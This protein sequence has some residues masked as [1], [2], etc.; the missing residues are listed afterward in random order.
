[1]TNYNISANL[2]GAGAIPVGTVVSTSG[3]QVRYNF[4]GGT[5]SDS[6]GNGNN[7]T[8]TG[9]P[10]P[11]FGPG[12]TGQAAVFN[13]GNGAVNLPGFAVGL[14]SATG[15]FSIMAW[16]NGANQSNILFGGRNSTN[17]NAIIDLV[18]DFNGLNNGYTGYA[19]IIVTDNGG[20]GQ[21]AVNGTVALN[22]N[23]WHHVCAVFNGSPGVGSQTL[24]LYV[25]GALQAG[26]TVA[27]LQSGITLDNLGANIGFEYLNGWATT[28]S[29]DD[30]RFY[31][32]ALTA[33]EIAVIFSGVTGGGLALTQAMAGRAAWLGAG[34][35]TAPLRQSLAGK[36]NW[37]G[38]GATS[39]Q[40]QLNMRAGAAWGG[41][42][43]LPSVAAQKSGVLL[44][45]NF[46][47]GGS[48]ASAAR[49]RL[50]AGALLVGSISNLTVSPRAIFA[51]QARL[52]GTG[53]PAL[54]LGQIQTNVAAAFAGGGGVG[55]DFPPYAHMAQAALSGAG[56]LTGWLDWIGSDPINPG[57]LETAGEDLLY[58][59]AS[60]LEKSLATV[61][62]YRLIATYAELVRDQWDPWAISYRNLG[63]LAWAMGVNLWEDDWGE[64]FRRWWVANQWT[65]KYY[66]GSDLGLQMAVEA[67]NCKIVRLTRPPA[68]FYPGAALTTAE[69]QAYVARFPQLRL[70]PYAPRPQLPWLNYLG[71]VTYKGGPPKYVHNGR[72][73]GPLEKFYPTNF[74]AGGSYLRA[75][76]V[77]EPRTG[78]ETQCTVRR[79]YGVLAGKQTPTYYDEITLPA[80]KDNHFYPGTGNKYYFLPKGYPLNHT[81]RHAIVLG[82]LDST[83]SR[84]VRVPRDGSLDITQFQA[85]FQ[86]I[87]PGLNPLQVRPEWV[88]VEHPWHKYQFYCK[89][90]IGPKRFL[91]KSDAWMYLYERWYLFDPTRLPDYRRANTYIGRSRFGIRKYSAEAKIAAYWNWPKRYSYYGGFMGPG[92]FFAPQNTAMIEKV[93][94]AVTASMA[95]RDTIAINT[96]VKR[97]I[98]IR[99]V[100]LL[101]GRFAAGQWIT[102]SS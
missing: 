41:L 71:G 95:A 9:S 4:D 13:G 57:I 43:S 21:T 83:A 45:A 12:Q 72:F 67:I 19:S 32:R 77:Y 38:V 35:A 68:L 74:N 23:T 15:S 99:D 29:I 75:C 49:Q 70:Y 88:F 14:A 63:Y 52:A 79:V 6:S 100:T 96:R 47:G 93:R 73:F 64:A 85:I 101:D 51:P 22:D 98:Q 16:I 27:P 59:N 5:A 69:R 1:V 2:V 61:D 94:R 62:A 18:T 24:S 11:T 48:M 46:T 26:P 89:R 91:V 102:D 36:A 34:S 42:G 44:S 31:S 8:L 81:R 60:G 20:A 7:G 30:F 40:V 86:T 37:A 3:L 82:A 92:R 90:S 80:R 65:F 39:N 50:T 56:K 55:L 84:L 53:A 17:G 87:V 25:D 78:L 54:T 28:G 66:R 97:Q 10:L 76:T 33:S 58:R